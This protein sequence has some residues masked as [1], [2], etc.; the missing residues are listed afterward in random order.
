[1]PR[2]HLST[3]FASWPLK[4]WLFTARHAWAV[5]A[6]LLHAISTKLTITKS[7]TAYLLYD[8]LNIREEA[9]NNLAP[10]RAGNSRHREWHV[11]RYTCAGKRGSLRYC[12]AFR[13]ELRATVRR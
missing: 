4:N 10:S 8:I 12:L 6:V 2:V 5:L 1:M 9:S 3:E 7:V 13:D 11:A